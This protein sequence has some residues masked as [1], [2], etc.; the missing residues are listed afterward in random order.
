MH[1]HS[2]RFTRVSHTPQRMCIND[3][4]C[5]YLHAC[6]NHQFSFVFFCFCFIATSLS[7]QSTCIYV[8][9]AVI[10]VILRV[11]TWTQCRIGFVLPLFQQF[12]RIS[13]LCRVCACQL[14]DYSISSYIFLNLRSLLFTQGSYAY[15]VRATAAAKI[16]PINRYIYDVYFSQYTHRET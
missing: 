15:R 5:I 8:S 7:S 13:S 3:G 14:R 4:Y 11:L 16:P 1:N 12:R 10:I 2:F 6:A 9:L